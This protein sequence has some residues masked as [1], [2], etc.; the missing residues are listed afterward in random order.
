MVGPADDAAGFTVMVTDCL[1]DCDWEEEDEDEDDVGVTTVRAAGVEEVVPPPG[2]AVC[3]CVFT[4]CTAR[5]GRITDTETVG[6]QCAGGGWGVNMAPLHILLL[7]L[8][9]LLLPLPLPVTPR[10]CRCLR[11]IWLRAR[12][13][14]FSM[15]RMWPGLCSVRGRALSVYTCE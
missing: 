13:D 2:M 6:F 15:A 7:P 1:W 9:P 3:V 5:D 4:V 11:Q 14:L 12:F 8:L 10:G